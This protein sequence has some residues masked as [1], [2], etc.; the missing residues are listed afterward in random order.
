MKSLLMTFAS[1]ARKAIKNPI[2][3]MNQLCGGIGNK[4]LDK[5]QIRKLVA[6][7]KQDAAVRRMKAEQQA[8]ARKID[9]QS[10]T[11]HKVSV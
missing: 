9:T 10:V 5:E 11:S 2:R 6:Q 3:D 7:R 8:L 4:K 1:E